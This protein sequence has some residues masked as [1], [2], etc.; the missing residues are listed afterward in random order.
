MRGTITLNSDGR[1]GKGRCVQAE[2]LFAGMVD[3]ATMI[4]ARSPT[5]TV[6]FGGVGGGAGTFSFKLP[7]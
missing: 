6:Q 3:A 7:W 2:G 1:T 5:S 4:G